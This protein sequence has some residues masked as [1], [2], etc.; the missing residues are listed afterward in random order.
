[1]KIKLC[2]IGCGGHSTDVHGPAQQKFATHHPDLVQL[3]ACCDLDSTRARNYAQQFGFTRH[4]T[5]INE[6]LTRER[7]DAVI[8]IAPTQLT[9]RLAMPILEANIPLML[10]KPPG[11]T[12]DEL[13]QLT[14]AAK[15][16][17]TP[18]LVAFNRRFMPVIAR[19]RAL[20]DGLKLS[21]S[22]IHYEQIRVQRTDPDFST[23]A[24]HA[25]DAGLYL[26]GSPLLR[27]SFTWHNHAS[28]GATVAT[29]NI[30]GVFYSG[31]CIQWKIHPVGGLDVERATIHARDHS[32]EIA[33]PTGLKSPPGFLRHWHER[34]LVLDE[35]F[36][37]PNQNGFYQETAA[38]ITALATQSP[39]P[40]PNFQDCRQ[41]V[42]LMEAF[43]NRITEINFS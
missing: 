10:E 16:H 6:M 11:L 40:A 37:P 21:S 32:L 9:M 35:A 42:A 23:T 14:A 3:V 24:I 5:A 30:T 36:T 31:A 39:L 22:S 7:P 26:A 28:L 2:T 12:L 38:F 43:R 29:V 19:A 18:Q 4:Y 8:L 1:M 33:L 41:S 17:N 25:L 34:H 27:A 13:D 20:L 15:R